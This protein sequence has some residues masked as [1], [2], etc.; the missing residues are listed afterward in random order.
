VGIARDDLIRVFERFYKADPSRT[1]TGTGLGLA[2]CKHVVQAHGGRI[3]A[4]S[5]GPGRGA[6]FRFTL[7]AHAPQVAPGA[8]D[9]AA[10]HAHA[11]SGNH[12]RR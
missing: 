5:D 12:R 1:G 9:G 10:D 4:E 8:A 11:L 3:S 7:P 6:T 2:I